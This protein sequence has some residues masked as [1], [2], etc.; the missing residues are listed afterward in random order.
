[1]VKGKIIY[2]SVFWDRNEF[3]KHLGIFKKGSNLRQLNGALNEN[4][5]FENLQSHYFAIL[6]NNPSEIRNKIICQVRTKLG[7][8][9]IAEHVILD[10]G[11]NCEVYRISVPRQITIYRKEILKPSLW[12]FDKTLHS[13][14]PRAISNLIKELESGV[15]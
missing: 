14:G 13:K 4:Q 7:I 12:E 9:P 10:S 11:K 8:D 1:M 15:V 5:Y 6:N 2:D 3:E